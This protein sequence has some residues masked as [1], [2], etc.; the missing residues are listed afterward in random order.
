MLSIAFYGHYMPSGIGIEDVCHDGTGTT[1]Y[2]PVGRIAL[3]VEVG[4]SMEYAHLPR[5]RPERTLV[6]AIGNGRAVK[7]IDVISVRRTADVYVRLPDVAAGSCM[8]VLGYVL[9]A[10]VY[11]MVYRKMRVSAEQLI[12]ALETLEQLKNLRKTR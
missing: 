7:T 12:A 11:L 8:A 9:S 3:A 5:T 4:V 10:E 1:A 2:V 6:I